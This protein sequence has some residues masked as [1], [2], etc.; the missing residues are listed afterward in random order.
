VLSSCAPLSTHMSDLV[1]NMPFLAYMHML[2]LN[3]IFYLLVVLIF[4][5]LI[6]LNKIERFYHYHY[7][8]N[9]IVKIILIYYSSIIEEVHGYVVREVGGCRVD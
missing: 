3:A 7:L 9:K 5:R 2:K 6:K 8:D 4:L 1:K